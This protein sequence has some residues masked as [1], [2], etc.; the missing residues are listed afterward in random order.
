MGDAQQDADQPMEDAID[1][2]EQMGATSDPVKKPAL[3][4]RIN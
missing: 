4:L 2:G 1:K 3:S